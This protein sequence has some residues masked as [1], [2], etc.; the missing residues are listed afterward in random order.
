MSQ[1]K[2]TEPSEPVV[3]IEDRESSVEP[4]PNVSAASYFFFAETRFLLL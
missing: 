4:E 2:E 1:E 3:E